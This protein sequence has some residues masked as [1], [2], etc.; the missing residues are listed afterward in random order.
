M[1]EISK[2]PVNAIGQLYIL[3]INH[4]YDKVAT[5]LLESVKLFYQ[6]NIPDKSK[7]T[8]LRKTHEYCFT[9]KFTN[10]ERWWYG[11]SGLYYI[12][13]MIRN[14]FPDEYD[15]CVVTEILRSAFENGCDG[16]KLKSVA[17]ESSN[18]VEWLRATKN[19][20]LARGFT[21][22]GSM[23]AAKM[24]GHLEDINENETAEE[25]LKRANG[26]TA[27]YGL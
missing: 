24:K 7:Y 27:R 6:P 13:A 22:I 8:V 21:D 14:K 18:Y 20:G 25:K 23:L 11:K 16:V 9:G 4:G 12:R 19:V 5:T 1:P 26:Y 10:T 2:M 15:H 17:S 3:I